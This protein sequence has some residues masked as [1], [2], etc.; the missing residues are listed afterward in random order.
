MESHRGCVLLVTLSIFLGGCRQVVEQDFFMDS[1]SYVGMCPVSPL[2]LDDSISTSSTLQMSYIVD[3]LIISINNRGQEYAFGI[4]NIYT[5]QLLGLYGRRGRSFNE[6]LD[7]LPVMDTYRNEDEE[8]CSDIF[9]FGDGRLFI[10]NISQS[11]NS[12]SD[13]YEDIIKLYNDEDRYSFL[14]LYHLDDTSVVV[15]NSRQTASDEIIADAPR[16]EIYDLRTGGL[17][18]Y[19]NIFKRVYVKTDDPVYTSKSFLGNFDCIKPDRTKLAFGMGYMPVYG[20]LDL[21]TGKFNGFKIKTLKHFSTSVRN[22]HFCNLV[23]DDY[24]IYALYYGDDISD[25]RA[26]RKH[27]TL[28]VIDWDGNITARYDLGKYFTELKLNDSI[29]YFIRNGEKIHSISLTEL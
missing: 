13:S 27:S 3:S 16:Y 9:S 20:I 6:M 5:D 22:W 28:F 25:S 14:S 1:L 18:R 29:L 4:S 12:A 8:L 19:F 26:E 7:C 11:L 2:I 17:V 21:E 23:A 10:W 15:K 24:Y